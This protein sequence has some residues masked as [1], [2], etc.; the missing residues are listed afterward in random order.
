[1]GGGPPAAVDVVDSDHRGGEHGGGDVRTRQCQGSIP[2]PDRSV[3]SEHRADTRDPRC[4]KQGRRNARRAP[5]RLRLGGRGFSL[6]ET[7]TRRDRYSGSG[8]KPQRAPVTPEDLDGEILVPGLGQRRCGS[9]AVGDRHV[10]RA[11]SRGTPQETRRRWLPGALSRR[12]ALRILG[13]VHR[14]VAERDRARVVEN[15][16]SNRRLLATL[17]R[18]SAALPR[19]S[20]SRGRRTTRPA[21]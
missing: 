11:S 3:R 18:G 21:E 16:G 20:W 14:L 4:K 9:H 6:R 1:V 15:D 2:S 13:N 10:R 8:A 5:R 19:T 7:G 17:G 12:V